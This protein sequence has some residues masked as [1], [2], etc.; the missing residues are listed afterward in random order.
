MKQAGCSILTTGRHAAQVEAVMMEE[1]AKM[2]VRP[3]L[4]RTHYARKLQECSRQVKGFLTPQEPVKLNRASSAR[5]PRSGPFKTTLLELTP[6][7]A[8][9]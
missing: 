9:E 1:F 4:K 5:G 3:T 2:G 6:Q 7:A 8:G